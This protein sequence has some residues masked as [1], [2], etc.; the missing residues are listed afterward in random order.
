MNLTFSS[1][2]ILIA[3]AVIM[4]T[5]LAIIFV[6]RM[7]FAG[8]AKSDLTEKYRNKDRKSLLEARNKYPEVDV[9]RSSNTFMRLGLIFSFALIVVAF[10]WTT[11]E[12]K[13]V[14]PQDALVMDVDLE[15]EPPRSAEPPPPPP[16]PPPPSI[17]EVPD[18]LVLE[19]EEMEFVDQSVTAETAVEAPPVMASNEEAPPPPPPP[20]PPPEPKVA[21]IFKVVEEMPRFPGCENITGTKMEKKACADQKLLEYIYKNIEYPVIARDNG[22]EGTVVVQFVVDTDG[23]IS[24][25]KVVRDI[26]GGCGEEAL[27]VV[28]KMNELPQRWIP[29]KQRARP[30]RVMFNL[31]V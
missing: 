24:N 3:V 30:V 4:V 10:N 2:E 21:E 13:V 17:E 29:G 6:G 27:R 12:K 5:I 19:E 20:P 28:K 22:I 31:P 9:F 11:F 18:E 25:A 15:I 7:Y 16:P 23:R 14:I 8:K 26:G 1:S